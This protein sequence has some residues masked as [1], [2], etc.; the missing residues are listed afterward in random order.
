M[1][2]LALSVFVLKGLDEPR[3][4]FAGMKDEKDCASWSALV[5]DQ[6]DTIDPSTN[7]LVLDN[8]KVCAPARS[9]GVEP[10]VGQS[11]GGVFISGVAS[12]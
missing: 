3:I 9:S 4:V 8:Y 11:S 5:V 7:R 6:R 10:S 1:L 12:K 2:Y